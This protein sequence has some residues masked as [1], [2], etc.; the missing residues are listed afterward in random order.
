MKGENLTIARPYAKAVFELAVQHKRLS[1]W[2]NM[3][4]NAALIASNDQMKW[5]L[6]HPGIAESQILDVF[7]SLLELDQR[8]KNLLTLLS[9]YRRLNILEEVLFLFKKR[10]SYYNKTAEVLVVSS[11]DLTKEYKQKLI[12]VLEEKLQREIILNCKTDDSLLGGAI[13]RIGDSVID[14]S[15]RNKLVELRSYLEYGLQ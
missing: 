15:G 13:V 9:D 12:K 7:F 4:E 2:L 5:L 1:E 10:L 6:N 3:L 8:E 14:G 11:I